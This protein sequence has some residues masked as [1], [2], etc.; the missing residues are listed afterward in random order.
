M[1]LSIPAERDNTVIVQPKKSR[2]LYRNIHRV[3]GVGDIA[4][5][6]LLTHRLD[7]ATQPNLNTG[8]ACSSQ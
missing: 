5:T 2:A 6:E 4:L 7:Q 3:I 8:T 1:K